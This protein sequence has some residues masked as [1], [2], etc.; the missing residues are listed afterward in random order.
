[1]VV[2]RQE[3]LQRKSRQKR[4]DPFLL[5]VEWKRMRTYIRRR[6]GN[7]CVLC[8]VGVAGLGE[9]RV[10]H[11]LPRKTHPHLALDEHN[12]RTLCVD[13]D[14]KRHFE[15]GGSMGSVTYKARGVGEGGWPLHEHPYYPSMLRAR[16]R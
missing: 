13:C 7:R 6:D 14:G 10:D 8:G 11:I 5:S 16:G 4:A 15:K 12:L 2:G 1:M 9:S 3:L